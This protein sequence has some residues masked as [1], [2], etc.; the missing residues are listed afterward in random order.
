MAFAE[1]FIGDSQSMTVESAVPG[2]P[3]IRVNDF[4]G[5]ISAVR[6]LETAGLCFGFSP[7][8][9]RA[10]VDLGPRLLD[11]TSLGFRRGQS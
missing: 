1:F 7:D 2:V 11:A 6:E 9:G 3:A 8:E 5:R 4:V 10:G